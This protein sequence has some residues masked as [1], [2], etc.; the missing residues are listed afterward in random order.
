MTPSFLMKNQ[1]NQTTTIFPHN[2]RR[3]PRKAFREE[4]R[5]KFYVINR[6]LQIELNEMSNELQGFN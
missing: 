6:I 1:N 3:Q 5:R 4:P 2:L